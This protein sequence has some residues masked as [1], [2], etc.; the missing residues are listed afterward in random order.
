MTITVG[1][2]TK[3]YLVY[4][5]TTHIYRIERKKLDKLKEQNNFPTKISTDIQKRMKQIVD[6]SNGEFWDKSF[7]EILNQI[8]EITGDTKK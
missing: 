5:T 4:E 1:Q 6:N 3:E 7:N 2:E 8:L